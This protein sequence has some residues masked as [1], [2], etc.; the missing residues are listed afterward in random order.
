MLIVYSSER[1]Y[2]TNYSTIL[3]DDAAAGDQTTLHVCH[4]QG[5]SSSSQPTCHQA[6]DDE[7]GSWSILI[8]FLLGEICSGIAM[9]ILTVL[10][11]TYVDRFTPPDKLPLYIGR[12]WVLTIRV[13]IY[14][15]IYTILHFCG[16]FNTTGLSHVKPNSK[17]T[18]LS[19][20]A[21]NYMNANLNCRRLITMRYTC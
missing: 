10:G 2:S 4:L 16:F 7:S 3:T 11:L 14:L 6:S 19:L 8:W 9:P 1:F 20:A 18:N 12:F 5:N 15:I 17:R 21:N 13:I